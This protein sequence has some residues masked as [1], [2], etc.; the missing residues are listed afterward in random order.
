MPKLSNSALRLFMASIQ[1]TRVALLRV[2]N[3]HPGSWRID[4]YWKGKAQESAVL[5][6]FCSRERPFKY[7]LCP[8]SKPRDYTT[9]SISGIQYVQLS[10][11]VFKRRS[12]EARV[13]C[14]PLYHCLP[15]SSE[16]SLLLSSRSV[17]LSFSNH[18][19][20]L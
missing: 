7:R 19:S 8:K 2:S 6:S 10:T 20:I 5:S 4:D 12:I 3:S 18:S 1:G 13:G 17:A 14:L 15:K 16:I 11:D 9:S